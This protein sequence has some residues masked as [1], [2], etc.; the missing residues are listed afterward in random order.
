MYGR[1]GLHLKMKKRNG[2]ALSI[3]VYIAQ[4]I[5]GWLSCYEKTDKE[6]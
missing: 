5:A 1:N 6:R 3:T 2:S 4:D